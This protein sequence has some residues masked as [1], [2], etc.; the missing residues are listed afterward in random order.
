MASQA[1]T[2]VLS[3]L[4]LVVLAS[5]LKTV[6]RNEKY[7]FVAGVVLVI[8]ATDLGTAAGLPASL[9]GLL[10]LAGLLAILASTI[11]LLRQSPATS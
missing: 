5:V 2:I 10:A 4:M 6:T 1:I 3:V 9:G 8:A 7:W 11:P